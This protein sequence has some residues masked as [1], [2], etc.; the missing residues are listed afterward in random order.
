M[1]IVEALTKAGR[2][3]RK[4]FAIVVRLLTFRTKINQPTE[5]GFGA[6]DC[7]YLAMVEHVPIKAGVDGEKKKP[8]KLLTKQANSL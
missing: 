6:N 4:C 7:S 5:R 1:V 2:K 3:K 8:S